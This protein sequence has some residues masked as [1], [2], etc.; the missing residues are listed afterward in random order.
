AA[1]DALGAALTAWWVSGEP[2]LSDNARALIDSLQIEAEYLVQDISAAAYL[3]RS[4]FDEI[5]ADAGDGN[6]LITIGAIV[7]STLIAILVVALIRSGFRRLRFIA[8]RLA[9]GD[10][11]QAISARGI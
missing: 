4:A 11:A 9:R 3:E 7:A 1:S 5:V 8:D 6:R 10:F 2:H